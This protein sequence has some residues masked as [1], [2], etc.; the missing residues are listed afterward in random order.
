MY[1]HSLIMHVYTFFNLK[2]A[3]TLSSY[4]QIHSVPIKYIIRKMVF[5]YLIFDVIFDACFC[6]KVCFSVCV[7]VRAQ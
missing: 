7:S 2:C 1:I 5:F 3:Y 6:S 4:M